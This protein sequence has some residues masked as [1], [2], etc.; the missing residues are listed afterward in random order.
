MNRPKAPLIG[1]S[2]DTVIV[3]SQEGAEL[4]EQETVFV[5]TFVYSSAKNVSLLL[6]ACI[7]AF[8]IIK[9][10][11]NSQWHCYYRYLYQLF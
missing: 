3:M 7:L 9:N 6:R 2:F 11:L 5:E 4:R 10:R 8:F 1:I